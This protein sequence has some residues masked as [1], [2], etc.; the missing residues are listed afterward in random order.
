MGASAVGGRVRTA[1][2]TPREHRVLARRAST[3]AQH[4]FAQGLAA[5]EQGHAALAWDWLERAA[6]LAP[7][8][9]QVLFPLA[10]AQ[11]AVGLPDRAITTLQT[12]LARYD[13]REGWLL[14]ASLC[15]AQDRAQGGGG[16]L[17]RRAV[18]A[19]GHLL[20]SYACRADSAAL[21][22]AVAQAAGLGPWCGLLPSGQLVMG[23][24]VLAPVL[25]VGGRSVPALAQG[26][27]WFWPGMGEGLHAA[28][29]PRHGAVWS[30]GQAV[31]P[32]SG[33]FPARMS[34]C[35]GLV[36]RTRHGLRGWAWFPYDPA[37]L[38]VLR[39]LDA[40]SGVLLQSCTATAVYSRGAVDRP[41]ACYR[42]FAVSCTGLQ[43]RQIRVVGPGGRD[44]AGSPLRLEPLPLLKGVTAHHPTPADGPHQQ[45][46]EGAAIPGTKASAGSSKEAVPLVPTGAVCSCQQ[47]GEVAAGDR[48]AGASSQGTGPPVPAGAACFNPQGGEATSVAQLVE[49]YSGASSR[50]W[51]PPEATPPPQDVPATAPLAVVVPVYAGYA[52]TLACLSALRDTL[53]DVPEGVRVVVVDDAMPDRRLAR[54]VARLCAQA[55]FTLLHHSAN[56]GFPAAVNTGLRFL[57]GH[58]V[59][60]LNADTLVAGPWV[61][62][63][64]KVAYAT[65]DT[66]TVTP[67]SNAAGIVSYPTPT[68]PAPM[69]DSPAVARLMQVAQA[70]NAGC[71]VDLPSA[72]GFCMFL[73]HDCLAATGLLREDV[74][75][76][77]YGE[78]N[79][80]SQRASAAGW[81]HVAAVGA[82]V[83]H[84]GG[85]SFGTA[86]DVLC[87]H[88]QSVLAYLHPGYQAHVARW[89]AA[90]PLHAARRRMDI[91]R[92]CA[93][94]LAG[95]PPR[96]VLLLTHD[97]GGG[98]ARV[99]ARRVAYWR[100][101][102][103]RPLVLRA[104][105]HGSVLGEEATQTAYPNLRFSGAADMRL[106]ER[107]LRAEGVC[108]VEVH[109][110]EGHPPAVINLPARLDCPYDV[111]VHDHLWLCQRVTLLG[112]DGHY[113][114]EPGPQACGPCLERLGR[115]VAGRQAVGT[116]LRR[117]WAVLAHARRVV[118]P[119]PEGA[120]RLRRHW[121]AYQPGGGA[122]PLRIHIRAFENDRLIKKNF[123][124]L[125]KIKPAMATVPGRG[126]L[127]GGRGRVRVCVVG[128]IGPDKGYDRVLA[129]AQDAARRDLPL[130]FVLVGHTPDDETLMQTGRVYVTGPFAASEGQA[131]V[132]A[133]QA[134]I[135]LLPSVWP[136]TWCF[137]LGD[138]W[139]A[140][141]RVVAFDLG[142]PA[143]R[144]RATGLGDVLPLTAGA[145][146]LN[147]MLVSSAF[148][149]K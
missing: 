72:C 65:A 78:E 13:V 130:E 81:R 102:G 106:L 14:L 31:F 32:P 107:L 23:G 101:Q 52:P 87:Q 75:A 126:V 33:L 11:Q 3:Q 44:L 138:M 37:R 71:A 145:E 112:A 82:F 34:Q 96:A 100:G 86:G 17:L 73:R 47:D 69:P 133:M 121:Q 66:G 24:G 28:A 67:L 118:V 25:R 56:T 128:A 46:G 137:A 62:E 141:L 140:G 58:D 144:I 40:Q 148:I 39:V 26:G 142:A 4:A 10:M 99:V 35:E 127:A 117:S 51:T 29:P 125:Q 89:M 115:R 147:N 95:R 70:A 36:W 49:G 123:Q 111:Y 129:A 104:T 139:R 7:E 63:L 9:A 8:S 21:A 146:E 131:L 149:K 116:Y 91:V 90:D 108:H 113:C 79:D 134:D 85:V 74:F 38:P 97:T 19:V 53:A 59:I 98:V 1:F 54:A 124:R 92:F 48:A 15:L 20:S 60:V 57:A 27:A 84:V 119:C 136:E 132:R 122:F 76:K 16:P 109:Y 18:A 64:R 12:L 80:F 61:Q 2:L 55:G 6:R 45:G 88:N 22:A 83:A 50:P 5:W 93:D 103:V 68:S 143:W 114:G 77:G 94:R 105:A 42:G 41:L 43:A 110:P 30:Q 135:G 120:A